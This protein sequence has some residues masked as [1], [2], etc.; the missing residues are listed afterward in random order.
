MSAWSSLHDGSTELCD[1]DAVRGLVKTWVHLDG[2]RP[3]DE[4]LD[5]PGIPHDTANLYFRTREGLTPEGAQRLLPLSRAEVP[6]EAT[7]RDMVAFTAPDG[8]TFSVT[9]RVATGEIERVGIYALRLPAGRLRRAAEAD[10]PRVLRGTVATAA[11]ASPCPRFA[12]LLKACRQLPART[13]GTDHSWARRIPAAMARSGLT[14]IGM[15]IRVAVCGTDEKADA[16]WRRCFARATPG[17]IAT[18]LMTAEQITAAVAHLD[19]P[20]FSDTA[21]MMVTCWGRR[22]S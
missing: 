2:I 8:H 18:G 3:L 19:D 1:F 5:A 17:L 6:D 4:V 16:F 10:A 12:E 7:F 13:H 9:L 21:W 22:P 14:D 11:S 20:A 15:T